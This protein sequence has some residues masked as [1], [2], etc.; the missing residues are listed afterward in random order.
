MSTRLEAHYDDRVYYF[1]VVEK[2]PQKIVIEMY[3]APY[4]FLQ[5]DGVWRNDVANQLQMVDGLIAAV[6]K[7][8]D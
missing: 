3:K 8:I 2:S 4:I 6:V 7:A 5:Q 1:T